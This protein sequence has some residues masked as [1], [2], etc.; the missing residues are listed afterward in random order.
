MDWALM[1]QKPEFAHSMAN[2]HD[3]ILHNSFIW[4]N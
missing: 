1:M 4:K 2:E 3:M